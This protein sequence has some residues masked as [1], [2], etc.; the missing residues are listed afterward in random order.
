MP[1]RWCPKARPVTVMCPVEPRSLDSL[2]ETLAT[3]PR[4][5]NS[6]LRKTERTHFGRWVV[7]ERLRDEDGMASS[8]ELTV[9]YLLFTANIDGRR[10][11][12]FEK[13]VTASS[14][15]MHRLWSHCIGYPM[16]GGDADLVAYLRRMQIRTNLFFSPYPRATVQKVSSAVSLRKSFIDFAVNADGM[17]PEYLRDRFLKW[18][19]AQPT[20]VTR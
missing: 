4:R 15:D 14:Q 16:G 6:P 8:D 9:P 7:I 19:G 18:Y 17:A 11:T 1:L 5:E 20:K 13:L 12:Y 10:R 2:K 3:L